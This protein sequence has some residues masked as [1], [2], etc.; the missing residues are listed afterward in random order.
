MAEQIKINPM[1]AAPAFFT[2]QDIPIK[3]AALVQVMH[4]DGDMKRWDLIHVTQGKEFILIAA[5]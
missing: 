2:L 1:I 3:G 4:W 5:L